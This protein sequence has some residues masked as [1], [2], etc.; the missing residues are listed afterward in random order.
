MKS[1]KLPQLDMIADGDPFDPLF[2]D[3]PL[4]CTEIVGLR[5]YLLITVLGRYDKRYI[6]SCF[7]ERIIL[8]V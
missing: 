7:A 6:R 2:I 4:V 3:P 5:I 8:P 1:I